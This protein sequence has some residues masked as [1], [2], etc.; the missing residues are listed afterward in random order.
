MSLS[1][2]KWFG[3][4]CRLKSHILN[5]KHYVVR[6]SSRPKSHYETLGVGREASPKEIRA[7]FIKQS[8]KHHPDS[9]PNDPKSHDTIVKVNEAY[10]VLGN[11]TRRKDYDVFGGTAP[12]NIRRPP[13]P[14]HTRQPP[15]YGSTHWSE[16]DGAR[17]RSDYEEQ[18][19][20]YQNW[21][22]QMNRYEA[23]KEADEEAIKKG[24]WFSFLIAGV[25]F[26]WYF[27]SIALSAR[28]GKR[29]EEK[30]KMIAMSLKHDKERMA[31]MTKEQR[32]ADFLLRIARSEAQYARK[33]GKNENVKPLSCAYRD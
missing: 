29:M 23:S 5:P 7:A 16:Q 26:A 31:N 25:G 10:S 9:N 3:C 22:E 19:K 13:Y 30:S 6:L 21:Q 28:A 33:R 32:E 24:L 1:T 18:T 2:S 15:F 20:Y 4:G 17:W 12:Q 8:K 14:T 11:A 27:V